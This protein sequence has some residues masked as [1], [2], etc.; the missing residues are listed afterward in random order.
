MAADHPW[1]TPTFTALTEVGT[2]L[3]NIVAVLL[4]LALTLTL[5]NRWGGP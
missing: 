4:F 1:I 3:L 5:I 2:W